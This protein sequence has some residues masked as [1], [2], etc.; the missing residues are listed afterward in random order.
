MI[1]ILG[2]MINKFIE[3]GGVTSVKKDIYQVDNMKKKY[4]QL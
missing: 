2:H 4:Q 1:F 3:K